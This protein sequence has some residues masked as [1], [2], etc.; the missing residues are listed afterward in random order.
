MGN[1]IDDVNA[2]GCTIHS[3]FDGGKPFETSTVEGPT[4]GKVVQVRLAEDGTGTALCVDWEQ[5]GGGVL[6]RTTDGG[7]T[8]LPLQPTG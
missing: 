7:K 5:E 1:F 2:A 4:Y 6:S 3:S 8:W